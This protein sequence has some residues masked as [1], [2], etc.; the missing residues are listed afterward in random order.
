MGCLERYQQM[1]VIFDATGDSAFAAERRNDA[2]E[3]LMEA[4]L[5]IRFDERATVF[6]CED[7]VVMQA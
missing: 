7:D 4:G 1:D 2:A 5:L 3:V 6:G